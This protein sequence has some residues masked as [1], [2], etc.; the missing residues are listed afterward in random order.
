[1]IDE[2]PKNI[3]NNQK[4]LEHILRNA[5][6]LG[7]LVK[8]L[9]DVAR[10]ESNTMT[11]DKEKTNLQQ[12]INTVVQDFRLNP[13]KETKV[14]DKKIDNNNENEPQKKSIEIIISLDINHNDNDDNQTD[15]NVI[16]DRSKIIQVL[17]NIISNSLNSILSTK[18]NSNING[19][20]VHI[21]LSKI[22]NKGQGKTN[23]VDSSKQN[24]KNEI[25]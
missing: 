24:K 13:D 25:Q 16:L 5:N 21:T 17:S 18:K 8:D 10:I 14:K 15:F 19:D 12:L 2:F 6:R 11:L 9:L 3:D 20:S 23:S 4:Y 22:I 7:K 1:M